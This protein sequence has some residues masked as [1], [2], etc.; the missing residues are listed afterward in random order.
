VVYPGVGVDQ[1][2]RRFHAD[3]LVRRARLALPPSAASR[4][5]A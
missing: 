2:Q 4:S 1:N 3:R 5:A